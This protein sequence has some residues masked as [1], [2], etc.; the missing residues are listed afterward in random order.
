MSMYGGNII[1]MRLGHWF[2]ERLPLW[3]KVLIGVVSLGGLLFLMYL[4]VCLVSQQNHYKRLQYAAHTIFQAE[5]DYFAT[6]GKYT[7][8]MEKLGVELPSIIQEEYRRG[9]YAYDNNQKVET[10][11]VYNAQAKN[12]DS[13]RV[14]IGGVEDDPN[15]LNLPTVLEI[16]VSGKF[17]TL[18]ASYSIRHFFGKDEPVI[19]TLFQCNIL[20]LHDK[21]EAQEKDIR[22]GG[23]FCKRLGAQ[24]SNHPLI[25]LF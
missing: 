9:G 5:Q 10:P 22:K 16:S 4:A 14:E 12:G 19:S 17:G 15:A 13:F 21:E 23:R 25:W 18:P 24:P 2:A 20:I 8:N 6:H 1:G 3:A 11:E 7:A